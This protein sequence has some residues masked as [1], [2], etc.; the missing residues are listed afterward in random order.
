MDGYFPGAIAKIAFYD[1]LL[2]TA[3]IAAHYQAM[4]GQAPHGS[5]AADCSF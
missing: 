1:R 3:Q 2:T 4:T 5:C